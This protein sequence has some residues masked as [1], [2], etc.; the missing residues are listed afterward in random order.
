[1]AEEAGVGDKDGDE[2]VK[3]QGSGP[4]GNV[5][6]TEGEVGVLFVRLDG[7]GSQEKEDP[8]AADHVS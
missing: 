7:F 8:D 6:R 3:D 5:V 2:E 4:S 1:M